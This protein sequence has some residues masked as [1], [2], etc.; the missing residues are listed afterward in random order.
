MHPPR[1]FSFTIIL[2][3]IIIVLLP[4]IY[5]LSAPFWI[6]DIGYL[7]GNS[8]LFDDRH[9]TLALNS[10]SIATGTTLFCLVL[11]VPLAF[12]LFQTDMW[13]KGIFKTIYLIP[14]LIPPYIHAIVWSH[15]SGF[16]KQYL[17]FDIYS[18]WGV[19]LVMTLAF[20]PVITFMT[21]S[22]LKSIDRNMEEVSLLYN[23]KWQTMTRITTPLLF[24]HI[25]SGA[26]FVFI[27]SVIDFGVS[28]ILRV[29]VYPVEIFIQFSAFY[30][31]R[32]ATILS[33]PLIAI[34]I[35]LV[36]LQ[37][38][39]MKNRSYFNVAGGISGS[40]RY[41]LGGVNFLVI[42]LVFIV[43]GLSA[44]LPVAVLLKVAGSLS[45]YIKVLTVTW[46]Q[47]IYSLIIA[48]SASVIILFLSFSLS[49]IIERSRMRIRT[50]LEISA[51]IPLAIPA[52]TLGI[53]L[54]KVWNQPVVDIVYGSSLIIIFGY[55][56][57][58]LPFS[59]ITISSG[60]KQI[61]PAMEEVGSLSTNRWVLIVMK[62]VTP[63]LRHSLIAGLFII[64][65]LSFGELGTTLLVI[66]PGNETI[67]IKTYN[68]MHYG[69]DHMVAALSLILIAIIL[70]VSG[71]FIFCNRKISRFSG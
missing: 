4:I 24:P 10:L 66:P 28:D 37:K 35:I 65:I 8:S 31:E 46:D 19:V 12:L 48:S 7:D 17:S 26:I 51:L 25:L 38:L 15:L 11:G 5:M 42:G 62:I 56:A 29:N 54:I 36:I 32:A 45:N 60:L 63:L 61:N 59:L 20:F 30:N 57:R 69:A 34:T 6:E 23:G 3:F 68:I 21:L 41:H 9:I 58:F 33:L 43:I 64:F 18:R 39:Y 67:P 13:F 2:L 70:T 22:G 40:I 47:I 49:C 44:G 53:G 55:I 27:F 50:I 71:L 16:I 1:S 14:F 52:T